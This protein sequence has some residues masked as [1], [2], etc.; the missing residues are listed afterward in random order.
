MSTLNNLLTLA[1]VKDQHTF[2]QFLKWGRVRAGE[3]T[4]S[5]AVDKVQYREV[6]HNRGVT[7][8]Y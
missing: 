3:D 8:L 4:A 1:T 7:V 2:S 6:L 5:I